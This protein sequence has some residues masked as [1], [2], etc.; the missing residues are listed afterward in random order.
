VKKLFLC[1]LVGLLLVTSLAFADRNLIREGMID[2]VVLVFNSDG[3]SS[4][5][6]WIGSGVIVSDD[7]YIVTN[8]HVAGYFLI[9]DG[10][11]KLGKD[12]FKLG[13]KDANLAVYQKGWGYGGCRIVAVSNDPWRDLALIK[14]ETTEELPYAEIASVQNMYPGDTV[15]AVGHPQGIEWMM[16]KGVI[17]KF[18]ETLDHNKLIIHDASINAGSSGG[19]LYDEFGLV[20]GLNFA[21][22]PPGYAENIAIAID[23]RV[24]ARFVELA[25]EF[26]TQRLEVMTESSFQ[27]TNRNYYYDGTNYNFFSGK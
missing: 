13:S 23:A 14:I 17:S 25:I 26:D 22:F 3:G 11:D 12:K 2:K 5:E 7:G 27:E 21:A 16:T 8:R 20:V 24:V 10:Q 4:L 15:Y 1:L 18:I 6:S 9:P 19:A